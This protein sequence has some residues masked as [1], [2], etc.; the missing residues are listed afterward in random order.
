[1]L[2][3]L[4]E[5]WSVPFAV[6]LGVP[7][8]IAG[9]FLG[10]WL[11]GMPSD[12]YF[13]VGLITIV[14]L[15][16]KNAILIVQFANDLRSKGLTIAQA[17][18]EAGRERLRPIL[19]TSFAFIFGVSPLVIASGAGAASRHSLGTGVVAGMLAATTI[20]V[21]FIPLFF[22]VIRSLSERGLAVRAAIPELA[23]APA[24]D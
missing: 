16:A 4:Y 22:A 11:R 2:A 5:S 19:M 9:A 15:A 21:F 20:G 6:L 1:V 8:G 12:V 24:D 3:A 17:A 7:F 10:I 14:G 18:A 23:P 13:Q